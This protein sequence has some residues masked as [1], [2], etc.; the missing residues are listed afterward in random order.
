MAYDVSR[1]HWPLERYFSALEQ[2]GFLVEALREV[3]VDQGSLREPRDPRWWRIP[4]FLH[5]RALKPA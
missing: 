3:T 5:V 4:L 2:A 1:Q